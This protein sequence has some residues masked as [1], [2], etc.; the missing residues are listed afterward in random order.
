MEN[1]NIFGKTFKITF[2]LIVIIE[3]LSLIGHVYGL[4]NTI[5]FLVI[6]PAV[7]LISLWRLEYGFWI[8]ASE[9]FIGS[10]G[11]MFFHDIGSFRISIRLGIFLAVLAAWLIQAI[12]NKRFE[13]WHSS[14]RWPFIGFMTFICLDIA[15][16]V[17][18]GNSQK[19]IFFDLNAYLFFGLIFVA[20]SV[21]NSWDRIVTLGQLFAAAIL[22]TA[23][24]T[25]AMLFFFS[26][27][28]DTWLIRTVYTW[29]RDTRVG[30]IAPITGMYYRIFFQG[31]IW[32]LFM[33]IGCILWLVLRRKK[34]FSRQH[35]RWLWVLT[36]AS[37]M[38]LV[39]SFS[40]SLWLA[41]AVMIILL[42]VYFKVKIRISWRRLFIWGVGMLFVAIINLGLITGIVNVKFPGASGNNVSAVSL[43]GDRLTTTDEAAIG[44][45]YQLLKPL[46]NK[47]LDKPILGSGF[48]TTVSYQ[49]LDPRTKTVN[50]GW[51]TTYAFE[52]GFL[53]IL[54]K[55]GVIGLLAYL[56]FIWR[57][58][59]AG[60]KKFGG[61]VDQ[62][63]QITITALLFCILALL[64]VHMTTPYLNHPLGIFLLIASAAIFSQK[65]QPT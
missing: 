42:A 24:K 65:T 18:F 32:S 30:E 38:S 64:T 16:A 44:S 58:I 57:V 23:L 47:F 12:K 41:F 29:I 11:Y 56:F 39:I 26:H 62:P 21:I 9:L 3:C 6:V 35:Y 34:E 31:H 14:L 4:I 7:F 15:T 55:I 59:S 2:W 63:Q 45:R 52:W 27:A 36:I 10:F 53:D 61:P 5:A 60:I 49:T 17:F 25:I 1:P 8:A 22:S 48:G 28:T 37:S 40:R 51:Y 13:F 43:I 54:V 19:N 46:L 33:L 20:F 50:G